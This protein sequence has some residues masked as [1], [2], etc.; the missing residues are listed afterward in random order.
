M[1]L[2]SAFG[3]PLAEGLNQEMATLTRQA[4]ARPGLGID[5][6]SCFSRVS[7][8]FRDGRLRW[9]GQDSLARALPQKPG[10]PTEMR[11]NAPRLSLWAGLAIVA[12]GPFV[13][14][15]RYP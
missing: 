8:A 14:D 4:R 12:T 1:P 10:A 15:A 11:F 9:L 3:K 6:G 7:G 5:Y 13:T 2:N